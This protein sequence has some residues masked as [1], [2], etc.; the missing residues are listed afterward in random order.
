MDYN[1]D[2][3]QAGILLG[4]DTARMVEDRVFR[5][6]RTRVT[7]LPSS[8]NRIQQLGVSVDRDTGLLVFDRA[9]FIAKL[10]DDRTGVERLLRAGASITTT[11]TLSSL[12]SGEGV[13]EV[14][15]V[16]DFQIRARNGTPFNVNLDDAATVQAVL[17]AI[18]NA[19][20]NPGV[21][22]TVSSDGSRLTL[23]D[24]SSGTADL[25]ILSINGSFAAEDLGIAGTAVY[26][27]GSS[28][29]VFQGST[30]T[31]NGLMSIV[32]RDLDLLTRSVDGIL[33][34]ADESMQ[35][36]VDDVNRQIEALQVRIN[37]E[38]ARL[39]RQFA[40]LES[41]LATSQT[42][43]TFLS[44]QF[45]ALSGAQASRGQSGLRLG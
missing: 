40:E 41:I 42:T 3:N 44:Q 1:P 45:A 16:N 35:E 24:S 27:C 10:Q 7:G 28:T 21:V 13:R 43:A 8:L 30:I 11:T 23:T 20:G 26:V 29:S 22:A 19:S 32:S 14:D 33:T 2:T 6:L 12:R 34:R 38:E 17:S 15:G 37:A 5:I 18:N 39:T 25:N 31:S 36:R 4:N 9:E